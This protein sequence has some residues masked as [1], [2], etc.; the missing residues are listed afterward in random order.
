MVCGSTSQLRMRVTVFLACRDA[1][2]SRGKWGSSYDSLFAGNL[3]APKLVKSFL[4]MQILRA[5]R[6][7]LKVILLQNLMCSLYVR[8]SLEQILDRLH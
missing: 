8:F 7:N 5:I 3:N 6:V 2:R 1:G 4:K